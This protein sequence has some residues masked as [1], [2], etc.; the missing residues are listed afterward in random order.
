M[1]T[2]CYTLLLQEEGGQWSLGEGE[3]RCGARRVRARQAEH[4]VDAHR[5][6]KAELANYIRGHAGTLKQAN[7]AACHIGVSHSTNST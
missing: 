2:I 5:S 6:H 4:C 3:R 1:A 7:M